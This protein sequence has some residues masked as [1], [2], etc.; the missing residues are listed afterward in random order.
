MNPGR[1]DQNYSH[2]PRLVLLVPEGQ[3]VSAALLGRLGKRLR[4]SGWPLQVSFR[5]EP[6]R[7]H[8]YSYLLR[9]SWTGNRSEF[10]VLLVSLFCEFASTADAEGDLP[11][12]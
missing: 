4:L 12:D 7:L 9:G 1:P 5:V 2:L 6:R 3:Q 11:D 8:G 10:H